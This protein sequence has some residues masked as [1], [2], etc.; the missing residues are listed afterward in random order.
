MVF[1]RAVNRKLADFL[2]LSNFHCAIEESLHF[3]RVI[4]EFVFVINLKVNIVSV[5]YREAEGCRPLNRGLI[6]KLVGLL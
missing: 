2:I 3:F 6:N 5:Y 4:S 1:S